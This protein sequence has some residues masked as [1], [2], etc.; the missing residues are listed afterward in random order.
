M[1]H[2]SYFDLAIPAPRRLALM[3]RDFA[4][5]P[6]RFPNCPENLKPRTWRDVR[7]WT[8]KNYSG[9]F[10]NGLNAGFNGEGMHRAPIWYTHEGPQFRDERYSDE[11]NSHIRYKGHYSDNE[12][13]DVYRGIVARLPH[14]RFLAGYEWSANDERVYFATVYDD[15]HEAA[16]QA[17]ESARIMAE[18][19]REWDERRNR[20]QSLSDDVAD[21]EKRLLECLALRNRP[22]MGYARDEAKRMVAAIRKMRDEL[23]TDYADFAGEF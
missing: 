17:D 15:E 6:A 20:A 5:H 21:S 22:C 12:G 18:H 8:L 16:E 14:G 2:L 23:A 11:V 4:G 13:H 19:E 7:G 1:S 10:V 9:A 3:R